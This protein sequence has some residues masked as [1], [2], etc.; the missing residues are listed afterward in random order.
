M[1]SMWPPL[2]A[3]FFMTYFY[4]AG[5]GGMAPSARTPDPLLPFYSLAEIQL[6]ETA[7]DSEVKC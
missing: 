6:A 1:K 5:G 3:I 2:V 4:W 7:S